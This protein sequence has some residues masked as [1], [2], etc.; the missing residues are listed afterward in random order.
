MPPRST[1]L[2]NCDVYDW[3]RNDPFDRSRPVEL[4]VPAEISSSDYMRSI[5]EFRVPPGAI[6]I[7]FLGQNGFLLKDASGPL[8]S[9]DLYLTNSCAE[10]YAQSPVRVDRQLPIF[11]EP[12]DLD[13]DVFITTHSHQDHADPATIA[14]MPKHPYTL[15]VGPFDSCRIYEECGVP[16]QACSLIHPGETIEVGT[17]KVTATFALPTDREDLNHTGI[18]L[19]F[20]NGITFFNTGDTAWADVLPSLLPRGVDV[21]AIC[22]N[23]GY[24]NLAVEQATAIVNA[25]APTVVI[26]C[27]YDMMINNVGSPAMFRVALEHAGSS[28]RFRLLRYYE[29]WVYT[30]DDGASQTKSNTQETR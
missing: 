5:R 17:T 18:L 30:K 20:S 28:A 8:L 25:T 21:C 22:I 7:W 12:E 6:A 24:H 10:T 16:V 3:G 15:F 13:V 4:V 2:G 14:R 19:T 9:I 26:P 23:G 29:P 1:T 11:I 27:H